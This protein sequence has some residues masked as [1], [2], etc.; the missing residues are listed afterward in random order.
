MPS[1]AAAICSLH[2]GTGPF[3]A[4]LLLVL[5]SFGCCILL[6]CTCAQ[7]DLDTVQ[8]VPVVFFLHQLAQ[9][10]HLHSWWSLPTATCTDG[11]FPWSTS[12]LTNVHTNK[13]IGAYCNLHCVVVVVLYYFTLPW[14]IATCTVFTLIA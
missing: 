8:L 3:H 2:K 9:I 1:D 12:V 11:V 14:H 4:N 6:L 5:P 7:D 10:L 13:Y